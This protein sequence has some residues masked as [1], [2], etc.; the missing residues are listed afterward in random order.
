MQKIKVKVPTELKIM[1]KTVRIV[2]KSKLVQDGEA[3]SG[4]CCA[5]DNLIMVG[6]N[7]HATERDLLATIAHECTHFV[8]AKSGLSD[9]LND[10]EEP[11]VVCIEQNLFPLF[12]FKRKAW[13]KPIQVELTL[14]EED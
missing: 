13:R 5:G 1:G 2:Y 14:D 9:L 8:I 3:L 4:L 11:L 7:E 10:H 12:N 6:L